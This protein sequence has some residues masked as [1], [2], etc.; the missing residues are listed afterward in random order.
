MST[1]I[2]REVLDA[3]GDILHQ[4]QFFSFYS[5]FKD[6]FIY[7]PGITPIYDG[8]ETPDVAAREAC[9]QARR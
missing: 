2:E 1:T 5:P 6:V 3:K 9:T 8:R 7:G 4:D